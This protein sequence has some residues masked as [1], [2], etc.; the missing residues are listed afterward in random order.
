MKSP[1]TRPI[2][3]RRPNPLR[4]EEL[5]VR[6]VPSTFTVTK[7]LDDGT[8]GTLR[9]AV[10]QA[11][12]TPATDT[13]K[14]AGGLHGT[15]ALGNEIPI[16]AALAIDGPGANQITVSGDNATRVFRVTGGTVVTIENL[17][18]ANG[19]ATGDTVVSPLASLSRSAEASSTTGG[20]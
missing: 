10:G 5:E 9:W 15:I 12:A 14:F 7:L 17:T 2:A 8:N 13:V 6:D 16:T 20:P 1:T 4:L 3:L 19:R 11:N 18:I